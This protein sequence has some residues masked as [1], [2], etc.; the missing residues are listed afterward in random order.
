MG[1]RVELSVECTV[2]AVTAGFMLEKKKE[3]RPD[4]LA[5]AG[6]LRRAKEGP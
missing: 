4:T 3:L 5:E 2:H 1:S 6:V